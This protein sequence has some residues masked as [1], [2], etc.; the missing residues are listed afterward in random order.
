MDPDVEEMCFAELWDRE[1]KAKYQQI[2]EDR[3]RSLETWRQY[4]L[5][6]YPRSA[7]D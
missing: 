2:E 3:Q 5:Q 4:N 6:Q 7:Q 1:V